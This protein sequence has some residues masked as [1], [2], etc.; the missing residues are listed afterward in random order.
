M[1]QIETNFL[2]YDLAKKCN[3]QARVSAFK[4][5]FLTV[6]AS[7]IFT[8]FY[9]LNSDLRDNLA[10]LLMTPT[11]NLF[12]LQ[13]VTFSVTSLLGCYISYK[14]SIPGQTEGW[15]FRILN[16][17]FYGFWIV[18][19]SVIGV[20]ALNDYTIHKVVECS[21]ECIERALTGLIVPLL[22]LTYFMRKGYIIN[23]YQSIMTMSLTAFGFASFLNLFICPVTSPLY[24]L[25]SHNLVIIPVVIVFMIAFKCFTKNK[26]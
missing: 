19:F 2:I 7:L 23:S 20:L 9:L 17:V 6:S 25:C 13:L 26:G 3:T 24:I 11:M 18:M 22:A 1:K 5:I 4:F 12:Y 16:T 15:K 8:F 10:H 14:Q 21:W